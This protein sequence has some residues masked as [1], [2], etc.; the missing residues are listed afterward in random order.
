MCYDNLSTYKPEEL[1]TFK[2]KHTFHAECVQTSFSDFIK[3]GEIT[4]LTCLNGCN[5]EN[6]V[7]ATSKQLKKLYKD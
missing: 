5:E 6:P 2:C 4:N 7:K 1:F 3:R